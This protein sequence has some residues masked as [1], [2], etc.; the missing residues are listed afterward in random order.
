MY[1]ATRNPLQSILGQNL[2]E[3]QSPILGNP[4]VERI[5]PFAGH[6]GYLLVS[7]IHQMLR[8]SSRP[9]SNLCWNSLYDLS[10]G[11]SCREVGHTLLRAGRVLRRESHLSNTNWR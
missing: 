3:T 6:K 1:F 5:I 10:S 7:M 11:R 8:R 9:L 4:K 2:H